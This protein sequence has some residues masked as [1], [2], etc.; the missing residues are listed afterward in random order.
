MLYGELSGGRQTLVKVLENSALHCLPLAR[1][2]LFSRSLSL[3]LFLGQVLL[4]FQR[5]LKL[6]A[7]TQREIIIKKKKKQGF[8]NL[9]RILKD[10][11]WKIQIRLTK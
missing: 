11:L 5:S 9:S 1:V 2:A 6:E 4:F 10:I 8:R 3:S 7:A